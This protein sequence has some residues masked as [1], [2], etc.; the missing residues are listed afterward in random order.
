[1]RV[2]LVHNHYRTSAP[3]GEDAVFRSEKAL[4]EKNGV[5]VVTHERFN[6]DIDD[7]SFIKKIR[8]AKATAWSDESFEVVRS[9]IRKTKPTVAHF[10]NTFPQVSPSAYAACRAEGVPVVQTL[11][12]YRFL[13]AGG[14]LLR[15]GQ[16]CEKCVGKSIFPAL[17]HKC[18]RNSLAATA[19]VVR[20]IQSN[21]RMAN[22]GFVDRF[23]ALTEAAKGRFI[24]GGLPA[25]KFLVKPNFVDNMPFY[26][27]PRQHHAV[28][29]GRL[30][31]EKGVRTLVRAWKDVASVSLHIYGDGE[32]RGELEARVRDD[33][34]KV[35]FHGFRPRQEVMDSIKSALVQIIPSECYEG[36]P[37]TVLEAYSLGIPLIVSRIGSLD[38]IVEE[39]I[40]GF[41]FLPGSASE[42][43]LKVNSLAQ[44]PARLRATATAARSAFDTLYSA[45][46]S[47]NT[48]IDLYRS[49]QGH[50]D[51]SYS[52]RFSQNCNESF[53]NP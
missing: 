23:I 42:L 50:S 53:V 29:V 48:L 16:P 51:N 27:G 1:M 34:S 10:H 40:T 7:S 14:L 31:A 45:E 28:Y 21:H 24:A 15:D 41:K 8:L 18:Y 5:D 33:R 49:L 2:M 46:R 38:E 35:V 12:N 26:V 19:V 13:C 22:H 47:F 11:H 25:E 43:A 3:S 44:R 39:G 36:F 9:T 30:T 52:T 32:L 6:D 17:Q 37:L 4:L 20:Y